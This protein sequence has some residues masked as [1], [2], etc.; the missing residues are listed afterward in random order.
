MFSAGEVSKGRNKKDGIFIWFQSTG[1]FIVVTAAAVRPWYLTWH[2]EYMI[3]WGNAGFLFCLK[4]FWTKYYVVLKLGIKFQYFNFSSP[5]PIHLLS[6][7]SQRRNQILL[8][9]K[10]VMVTVC[11]QASVI[12]NQKDTLKAINVITLLFNLKTFSFLIIE[13]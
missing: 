13:L 6:W 1:I 3:F 5:L 2:F 10:S 8:K 11:I 12:S 7:Y 9:G 4:I